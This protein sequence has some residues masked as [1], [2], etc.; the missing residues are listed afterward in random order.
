MGKL[1][2][3]DLDV[4]HPGKLLYVFVCRAA[5][6]HL[7]RTKDGQTDL[8]DDKRRSIWSSQNRELTFIPKTSPPLLHHSLLVEVGGR[9]A[10]YREFILFH[11]DRIYPE[12]LV[13]YQRTK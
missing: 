7:V 3:D 9:I 5:L 2:F 10:R 6:G 12:Y 13:A 11:G 1:L 4:V 8:E